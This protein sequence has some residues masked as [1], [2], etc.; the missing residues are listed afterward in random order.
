MDG[1]FSVL[2]LSEQVNDLLDEIDD[3]ADDELI[4]DPDK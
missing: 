3:L 4:A 1:A 2:D